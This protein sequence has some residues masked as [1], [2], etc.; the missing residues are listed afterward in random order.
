MDV[1]LKYDF[2]QTNFS[3]KIIFIF[4]KN[5]FFY[6]QPKIIFWLLVKDVQNVKKNVYWHFKIPTLVIFFKL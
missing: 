3:N 2:S 1:L 6:D 5:T 4:V